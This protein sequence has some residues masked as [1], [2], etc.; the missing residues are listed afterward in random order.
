MAAMGTADLGDAQCGLTIRR[1]GW[2]FR[3]PM[4]LFRRAIG[5]GNSGGGLTPG[6]PVLRIQGGRVQTDG[7]GLGS[8]DHPRAHTGQVLRLMAGG[9]G[10]IIGAPE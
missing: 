2:E 10:R 4:D 7:I 9:R 8:V 3:T 5:A 1:I 6:D